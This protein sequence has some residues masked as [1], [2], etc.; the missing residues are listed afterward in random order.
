MVDYYWDVAGLSL[1][2]FYQTKANVLKKVL[3]F[4]LNGPPFVS[5]RPD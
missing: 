4:D 2:V 3:G 1:G 5:D